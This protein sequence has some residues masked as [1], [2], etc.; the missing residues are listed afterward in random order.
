MGQRPLPFKIDLRGNNLAQKNYAASGGIN[1]ETAIAFY[2]TCNCHLLHTV[3]VFKRLI[4]RYFVGVLEDTS[5]R[6]TE[7]KS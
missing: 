3:S 2:E 5:Y 1:P 4:K 6:Q 7:R